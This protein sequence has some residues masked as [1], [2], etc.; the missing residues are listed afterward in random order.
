MAYSDD[1]KEACASSAEHLQAAT[2]A[3]P[4]YGSPTRRAEAPWRVPVGD[5]EENEDRRP[6]RATKH[7]AVAARGFFTTNQLLMEL[8]LAK[9]TQQSWSSEETRAWSAEVQGRQARS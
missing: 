7:T 9:E 4:V 5:I 2:P 8:Q 3:D 1:V 6:R